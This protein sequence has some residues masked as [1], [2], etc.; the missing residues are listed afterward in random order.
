[1]KR[2]NLSEY[3]EDDF[4]PLAHAAEMLGVSTVTLHRRRDFKG[5]IVKVSRGI[6]HVRVG[7]LRKWLIRQE[8][9]TA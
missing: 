5:L 7:A 4:I 3:G 8:E 6:Y 9:K 1:M 2:I